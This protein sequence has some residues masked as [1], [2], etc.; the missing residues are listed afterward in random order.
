LL[1]RYFA[2]RQP[3]NSRERNLAYT[4]GWSALA[5]VVACFVVMFLNVGKPIVE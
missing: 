4:L 3:M 1:G 2:D 5:V